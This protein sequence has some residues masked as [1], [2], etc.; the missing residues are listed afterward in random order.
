MAVDGNKRKKITQILA[1]ET[2][3]KSYKAHKYSLDSTRSSLEY[4]ETEDK[5]F[6]WMKRG[7]TDPPPTYKSLDS[8][9]RRLS[10]RDEQVLTYFLDGSRRVYKVDDMA[11]TQS[12]NRSVIYPIIA[13]QVGVGICKRVNKKMSPEILKKEIVLSVPSIANPN[14]RDGFFEALSVKLNESNELARIKECGWR[15]ATP[16]PYDIKSDDRKFEDRGT[17]RIQDEMIKIEKAMV[18]EL[19]RKGKLNQDN[20][21]VKDGSLEY[22]LTQTDRDDEKSFQTFRQNYNWVIGLSKTFNPEACFDKGKANPGYI[23]DLPLYH[24]TPVAY[25]GSEKEPLAFAVWY[26]RLRD[27]SKTRTPFDGIL[28]VEKILV[29]DEELK[30]GMDTE[31]VDML[32]ALIIN[33]RNPTSYGL[34]IRWANHIYPIYLTE[35]FVKSQYLGTESFLHLF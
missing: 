11:Y 31:T 8:L 32:S 30:N 14:G 28:K 26:V 7:E 27:K 21:L 12:G 4:N 25:F 19:V 20:Y 35:R 18:K 1:E 29:R 9:A 3:S 33:E 22:R 15:F 16:I 5:T 10:A 24:R 34:D 2:F 13:G 6:V 17:A 23:A